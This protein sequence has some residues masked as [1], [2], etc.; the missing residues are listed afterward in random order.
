Q[1]TGTW[2]PKKLVLG[3]KPGAVHPHGDAVVLR[4]DHELRHDLAGL[5]PLE[6]V[7]QLPDGTGGVGDV[8]PQ[9]VQEPAEDPVEAVAGL[10]EDQDEEPDGRRVLGEVPEQVED[11]VGEQGEPD[12]APAVRELPGEL[13]VD[14]EQDPRGSLL[15]LPVWGAAADAPE[16]PVALADVDL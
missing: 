10:A 4:V 2:V 8:P 6:Q 5:Q 14:P 16:G 13:L 12:G 9:V 15:A 7:R 1:K 11:A 3:V